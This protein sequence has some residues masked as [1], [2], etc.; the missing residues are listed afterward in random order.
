MK[1]LSQ[2][3]FSS[4][5][6]RLSPEGN[7]KGRMKALT[8]QLIK[9]KIDVF[10]VT[11]HSTSFELDQNPYS[12]NHNGVKHIMKTLFGYLDWC[13]NEQKMQPITSKKLWQ[14]YSTKIFKEGST[15]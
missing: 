1:W 14:K 8:Y 4:E 11:V 2:K 6:V 15:S 5:P 3:L 10:I 9:E 13:L 7:T 12:I